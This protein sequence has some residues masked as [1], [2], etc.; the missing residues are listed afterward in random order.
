[1]LLLI[2]LLAQVM[3]PSDNLPPITPWGDIA[4]YTNCLRI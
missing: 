1:M 4:S 2:V 3:P